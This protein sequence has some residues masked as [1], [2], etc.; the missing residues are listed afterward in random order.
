LQFGRPA[1]RLIV[2]CPAY[3]HDVDSYEAWEARD[4]ERMEDAIA[5]GELVPVN[6]GS[7]GCILGPR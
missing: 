1:G 5:A 6:I 7:D 3:F 4:D 2:W